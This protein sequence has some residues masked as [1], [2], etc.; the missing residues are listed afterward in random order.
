MASRSQDGTLPLLL[1]CATQLDLVVETRERARGRERDL[2]KTTV[3]SPD[4][5]MLPTLNNCD[6]GYER[7]ILILL[8]GFKDL[9]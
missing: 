6:V 9:L 8:N 1:L 4:F 2:I 3:A 7:R 5:M